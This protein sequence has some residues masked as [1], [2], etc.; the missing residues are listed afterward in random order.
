MGTPPVHVEFNQIMAE[1][2]TGGV[3]SF[4]I[5]QRYDFQRKLF[6]TDLNIKI[7]IYL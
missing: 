1:S 6:K 5:V 7:F 3:K 4:N 2:G